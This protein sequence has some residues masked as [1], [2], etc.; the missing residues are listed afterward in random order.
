[1]EKKWKRNRILTL[2][3]TAFIGLGAVCG[4]TCMFI[5]PSGAVM[6]MDALLPYFHKMPL[7]D[8][9]FQNYLFPGI[10]LLVVNG[11]S[12]LAAFVL[13]LCGRRIGYILGWV[14]GIT[15]MLWICIQFWL[16]APMVAVLDVLYIIFG[17]L[18]FVCG[19]MA[20]VGFMQHMFRFDAMD[21]PDINPENRDGLVVYFSRE[22]YTKRLA[23]EKANELGCGVCEIKARERT[24]GVLGFWWCGRFGMLRRPME[25]ETPAFDPADY[26]A[27]WLYSPVWVF[28]LSAPA[29]QFLKTHGG[30]IKTLNLCLTHFQPVSYRKLFARLEKEFGRTFEYKQSVCVQLG[31]TKKRYALGEVEDRTAETI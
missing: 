14:F 16:F 4:A 21:Y 20:Y 23:Y 15:L 6:G 7:A 11:L 17:F 27:V 13:I 31:L 30:R 3:W 12:N 1:M 18:Q 24:D 8:V 9:L 26:A 19:Y 25:I 10:A 28:S 5:D 29:R 2:F 22:G